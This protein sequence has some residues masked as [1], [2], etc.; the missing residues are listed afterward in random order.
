[1]T[2]TLAA[3][4]PADETGGFVVTPICPAIDACDL[5]EPALE[6]DCITAWRD[7]CCAAEEHCGLFA[8][9]RW[10]ATWL[11]LSDMFYKD[12]KKVQRIVSKKTHRFSSSVRNYYLPTLCSRIPEQRSNNAAPRDI[13]YRIL[14]ILEKMYGRDER[15]DFHL[16]LCVVLVVGLFRSSHR[17]NR[18]ILV[19]QNS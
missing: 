7:E 3:C 11:R 6:A 8:A 4:W 14:I 9:P 10:P 5:P 1:M 18:L 12:F 15:L 13:Y 2:D 16:C 17:G 19:L